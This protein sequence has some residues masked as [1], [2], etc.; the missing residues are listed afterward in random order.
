MDSTLFCYPIV[1]LVEGPIFKT[2]EHKQ[3]Q[4]RTT[5]MFKKRE[6]KFY[7]EKFKKLDMTDL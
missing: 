7:E 3:V 5:W 2:E 4:K 1:Y 6:V